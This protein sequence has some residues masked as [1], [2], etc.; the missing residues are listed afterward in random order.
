M[1][2]HAA[3]IIFTNPMFD[4]F[5][6]AI[7]EGGA[8]V[9]SDASP[10]SPLPLV[11]TATVVGQNDFATSSAIAASGLL[12][13]SAEADSTLDSPSAV[14]QSHF[15]AN[16]QGD[17]KHELL[18]DFDNLN[19]IVGGGLGS[20]N[21]F[22]FLTTTLGATT[23]TVFNNV[24]TMTGLIDLNYVVPAGGFST[25]D[26]LLVSEASTTG[27]GQSGQNFAQVTISGQTVPLPGTALLVIAGLL[28]MFAARRRSASLSH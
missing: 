6:V 19:T 3:P 22:V 21:L 23:T 5:A 17:G 12:V 27:P 7:A 26:L 18:L 16:I 15:L 25:I 20:G 2:G 13:T 8:D 28:A 9:H 11:T 4:T 24:I 1:A 14:G 10:S